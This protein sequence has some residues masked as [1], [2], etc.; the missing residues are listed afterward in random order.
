MDVDKILEEKAKEI[1]MPD[2]I[3]LKIDNLLKNEETNTKA[4]KQY[5]KIAACL[6]VILVFSVGAILTSINISQN[7]KVVKDDVSQL[8]NGKQIYTYVTDEMKKDSKYI[9]E[10]RSTVQIAKAYTPEDLLELCDCVALITVESIE[11]ASREYSSSTM[12]YG[13]VIVNNVILG[14][15]KL[16]D[17]IEYLKPG[18]YITVAEY[19][20]YEDGA[21]VTEEQTGEETQYYNTLLNGDI[22][23]EVGKTYLAYLRY[24]N[25]EDKYEIIGLGNGLREINIPKENVVTS[26]EYDLDELKILNNT[27]NEWESLKEYIENNI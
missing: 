12:T 21:E 18:G 17:E 15:I 5:L 25:N 23:I 6:I 4:N 19:D 9:D 11:G 7:N 16:G 24:D 20:K 14:D 2:N 3:N 22:E 13:K 10:N 27:T 1:K 26:K 8:A